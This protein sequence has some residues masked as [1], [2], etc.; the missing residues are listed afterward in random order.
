MAQG[1]R[2]RL[3]REQRIDMWRRWKAGYRALEEVY[4]RAVSGS[5]ATSSPILM[6]VGLIPLLRDE[7]DVDPV[8]VGVVGVI[9]EDVRAAID[10]NPVTADRGARRGGQ[11]P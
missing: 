7:H 2:D 6:P 5:A 4:R 9:R 3:S 8:V 1:K 10:I 11:Q